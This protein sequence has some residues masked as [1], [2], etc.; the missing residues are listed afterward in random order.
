M[1]LKVW[2]Q[3]SSISIAW[4]LVRNADSQAPPQT[5][6]D[7]SSEA[8]VRPSNQG[9]NKPVRCVNTEVFHFVFLDT[10]NKMNKS[11]VCSLTVHTHETI[12]RSRYQILTNFFP[13]SPISPILQA[14]S[15]GNHPSVL[16]VYL[17]ISSFVWTTALRHPLTEI[18]HMTA[19]RRA[20][21]EK[22]QQA[23]TVS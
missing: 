5:Y 20:A 10:Y 1:V 6:W 16:W 9:F 3:A 22:Q 14:L 15:S 2:S 18:P 4:D 17:F 11:K 19:S 8:G 7:S 23:L 21:F 13:S 12:T